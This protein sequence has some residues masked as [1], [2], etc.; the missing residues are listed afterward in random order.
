MALIYGF[1]AEADPID[2]NL[3]EEVLSD[4]AEF[5]ALSSPE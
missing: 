3:I 1:S 4:K 2:V 5:G